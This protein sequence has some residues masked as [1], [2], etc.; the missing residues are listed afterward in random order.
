MTTPHF[1]YAD[2]RAALLARR[3]VALLD[4]REEDQHAQAH[5]LF[6]ASFPL[7]RIEV[8]AWTKLPRRTVQIVLV[9]DGEGE[10]QTAAQRLRNLGYTNVGIL[11]GGIAAWRADGGELFRDVNV[12]SKAFGELVEA[13]CGTPSLSA[14]E[15]LALIEARADVVVV[16]ARRFE[17]F[18]TMS[19]P[20]GISVP[21]ADLVLRVPAL[22]PS[23]Q[24][25]V[26]VNCAGRTRSI[27]G[28]QSLINSGLPNPVVA[29]RNGTIGWTLAG[30]KLEHGATRRGNSAVIDATRAA[31]ARAARDVAD[32]AGVNRASMKDIAMWRGQLDR[33]T[34]YFDV[35]APEEYDAGHVRHFRSYP[36]GQLVQ[37][38]EI[39]APVRGARIVLADDDGVRA[40]MTASWLAQ[41][42]W[43]VFVVDDVEATLFDARGTSP[44]ELPPLPHVEAITADTLRDWLRESDGTAVV[45][46]ADSASYRRAHISGAW[47]ALRSRLSEAMERI[48]RAR[49]YVLTCADGVISQYASPELTALVPEPVYVLAGGNRSWASAGFP[50]EQGEGHLA[51]PPIDRYRRPYEGVDNGAEAMRA[52]LE[53]EFGLVEQLAR[54]GTHGFRVLC[55]GAAP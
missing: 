13:T 33:T 30:Q 2:V 1:H 23:A 34:Y 40:N 20:G 15:V 28:T 48:P 12:P 6:A 24:T 46:L 32:R 22:A 11:E 49:R 3:E 39:A 27:I 21:G 5:P 41:M 29:L 14:Q 25:R 51:S 38:T 35:R 47:F 31:S 4:V 18:R 43:D 50:T 37:E 54:D 55:A 10:A 8:D 45:D 52:Y 44:P 17:E 9:D 7:A 26:I 42:G 36:G 53:W 16:D 19:L